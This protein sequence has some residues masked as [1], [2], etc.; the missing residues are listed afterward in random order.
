M[1]NWQQTLLAQYANAPTLVALIDQLDQC[2]DPA[3]DLDAFYHTIWNVATANSH[4]LDIWGRIVNVSRRVQAALPPA[5][6]G[7]AE[8]FNA[9]TPT[10]GVQPFN[11]GVFNDG[12]PPV[13]RTVT[14]GTEPYR[15]LI[16]TKAMA[17]ITDCSCASLNQLLAYLF[18]GRGRCYALDTG[19]M[20]M[21]YVFE[22]QL[23]ILEV[24]VLTQSG[25]LPRPTGVLCNLVEA[26]DDVFGFSNALDDFQPFNQGTFSNGAV[27]A[28]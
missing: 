22:F 3:T 19:R 2:I 16:M 26:T 27:Y 15:T 20:T 5:E 17:N 23:S 21:Q 24:A 12:S 10:D 4:G 1:E 25:V 14:L 8:A 7:F 18:A 6:F 11:Y 9:A 13:V 28:S